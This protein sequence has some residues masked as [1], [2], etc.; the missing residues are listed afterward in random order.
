MPR[1]A[2]VHGVIC[3]GLPNVARDTYINCVIESV[4]TSSPIIVYADI[5][6]MDDLSAG[7]P[8]LEMVFD[9][10]L[11]RYAGKGAGLPGSDNDGFQRPFNRV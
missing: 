1:P 8:G 5:N 7:V 2:Q 3:R 11:G 10:S 6:Q 9:G 4:V